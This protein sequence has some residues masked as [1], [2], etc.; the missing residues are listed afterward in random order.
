MTLTVLA[1]L[2]VSSLLIA[3]L[4]IP[5]WLEKVPPNAFYGFRTPLTVN[6]PDIWYPVNK[7]SGRDLFVSGLVSALLPLFYAGAVANPDVGLMFAF[8]LVPILAGVVHSFWVASSIAAEQLEPTEEPEK[9]QTA[10]PKRRP[11]RQKQSE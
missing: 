2:A 4:G 9:Q 3:G 11:Q 10:E 5:L 6:Q 7:A 8:W 1:I